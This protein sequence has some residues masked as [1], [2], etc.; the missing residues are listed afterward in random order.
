MTFLQASET[1]ALADQQEATVAALELRAARIRESAGSGL[2]ASSIYLPGDGVEIARAELQ[3]LLTDA[4]GEASGRLIETQEPGSVRDADAPDDGRV[5]LRVTF[6]VTN[7]GLLEM[8]YGL[9]TRLPLLTI[10]RLEARRLD[11]EADAADEDPTLRVSL[12]ARG[13]RK[14]PS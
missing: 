6:D 14:L 8:L 11:A 13:H 4:V 2:D 3:K 7:D 5:E 1:E 9:E 12:V 10:E